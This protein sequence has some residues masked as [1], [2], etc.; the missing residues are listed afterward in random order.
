MLFIDEI[1]S[2]TK[3]L[4]S[5]E[6][7]FLWLSMMASFL[8][9]VDY[10]IIRPVSQ[11]IF[12]DVYGSK[13]LPYVWLYSLPLNLAVV[14]LYNWLLPRLGC[15]SLFLASALSITILNAIG[16]LFIHSFSWVPF[17]FYMWK[18]IYILLMLQQL[19]SV[20]H[21]T[22][23][24]KH[25]RYLYGVLFG[26]GALGGCCGSLVPGF[27]AVRLG[28][29]S[30]LFFTGPIYLLLVFVYHKL[31]HNSGSSQKVEAKETKKFSTLSK[32][33]GL[34]TS[35]KLLM[36]ILLMT[37][38]M[39]I[40]ATL[41]DFQFQTFLEKAYPQKDLRTEFFGKLLSL[42]NVLTMS[43]QFFGT[44]LAIHFL[45]MQRSHLSVPLVMV[46]ST[47]LFLLS[48]TLGSM[49]ACFL[50]VKCFDFSLFGV[51]KEMLYIPMRLEEKF[52]AKAIIDVFVHRASKIIASLAIVFLQ[53]FFPV[54]LLST[55]SWINLIVFTVWCVLVFSLKSHYKEFT[56]E[57]L[58]LE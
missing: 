2:L 42:G 54:L 38:F 13:S 58:F 33:I 14:S 36:A 11:S 53:G 34:I 6:R 9:A 43:F 4:S 29:E 39:Q 26:F 50:L 46:F 19:W 25:A 21:S 47:S 40:T 48:P 45:G 23:K 7:L 20:I 22:L 10:A 41:T 56:I 57:A 18:E 12:L 30:L 37:V 31:L 17:V 35:S 5:R 24:Q 15:F 49:A 55:I 28:S 3:K 16:A 27:F 32:G 51:I 52:Q 8:I 44:F 1:I